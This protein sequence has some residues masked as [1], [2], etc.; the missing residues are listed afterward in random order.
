MDLALLANY[1]KTFG[2]L[3]PL[4]AFLLIALQATFPFLPYGILTA[5]TAILFGFKAGFLISWIGALSGASISYWTGRYF[6]N[7][8]LKNIFQ[9]L[10]SIKIEKINSETAFWSIVLAHII[11]VFPISFVNIA[12][13]LGKVSYRNFLLSSA[14]GIFPSAILYTGLGLLLF[15][16]QD[17]NIV[18]AILIAVISLLILGRYIAKKHLS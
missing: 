5:A 9:K 12:A 15:K 2:Y 14:I 10:F 11:P 18:L 16:V 3:A 1:I 6:G 4:I 13:V 8:F 7:D 17:I